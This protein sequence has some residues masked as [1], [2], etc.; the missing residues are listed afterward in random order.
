MASLLEQLSDLRQSMSVLKQQ[1]QALISEIQDSYQQQIAEKL[2]D[3]DYGCG[4]ATIDGAKFIISKTVKWNQDGLRKLY[5]QIKL[6]NENPDEY[7]KLKFD[8]D[9]SHFG[10][11]NKLTVERAYTTIMEGGG[12][13]EDV[14]KRIEVIKHQIS[15]ANI[16]DVQKLKERLSKLSG[17]IAILNVGA[18]SEVEMKEKKARIEDA[19]NATRAAVD[20]GIVPGGGVALIR[21]RKV[22]NDLKLNGDEQIGVDIIRKAV[23]APL[24]QICSNAGIS[25]DMAVRDT[26][27]REGSVGINANTGEFEDLIEAGVI[28]PTKV[29]RTAL[30]NAASVAGMM[31]TTECIIAMDPDKRNKK[32]QDEEF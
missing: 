6:G 1:E 9:E 25:G 27:L 4:T 7:I 20:E 26:E 23:E 24:F 29:T 12:D 13:K 15:E 32:D 31:L 28:D 5:D 22:L 8:V 17:G 3:K 16:H 10:S 30:E 19:L 2:K 11:A 18:S 14:D 21:A